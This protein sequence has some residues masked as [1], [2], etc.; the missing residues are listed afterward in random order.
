[1]LIDHGKEDVIN[2]ST[3]GPSGV[4]K[5]SRSGVKI[6]AL[7]HILLGIS[8]CL[9]ERASVRASVRACVCV[10]VYVWLSFEEEK[11]EHTHT[12]TN[13]HTHTHTHTHTY[14]RYCPTKTNTYLG[15][16]VKHPTLPCRKKKARKRR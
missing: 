5:T 6:D 1:M 16:K 9:C 2:V 15:S 14:R 8:G 13:T 3:V 7:S 12:H 11:Q 10:V 4:M